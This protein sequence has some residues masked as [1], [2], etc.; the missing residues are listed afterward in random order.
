MTGVCS[1]CRI[2]YKSILC[3]EKY[4]EADGIACDSC[5]LMV[6]ST[7][8]LFCCL[9]CNLEHCRVCSY[10]KTIR[11]QKKQLDSLLDRLVN[12]GKSALVA[13]TPKGANPFSQQK[14]DTG[15]NPFSA[16]TPTAKSKPANPFVVKKTPSAHVKPPPPTA[17]RTMS[18][19]FNLGPEATVSN[20]FDLGPE[21]TASN[22]YKTKTPPA[23]STLEHL[24]EQMQKAKDSDDFETCISLRKRIKAWEDMHAELKHAKENDDFETCLRIQ[25]QLKSMGRT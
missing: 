19:P 10:P 17:K 16:S 14:S 20:P 5:G 25:K 7:Q 4:P 18:N 1:G 9:T 13:E 12:K 3:A 23:Q 21:A 24:R 11:P 15:S 22:H 8:W 6:K 2:E